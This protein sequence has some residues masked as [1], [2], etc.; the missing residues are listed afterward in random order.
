MVRALLI[1]ALVITSGGAPSRA[2][3]CRVRPQNPFALFDQAAS[4]AVVRV[5]NVDVPHPMGKHGYRKGPVKATLD[6]QHML[7]GPAVG[8]LVARSSLLTCDVNFQSGEIGIVMLGRNGRPLGLSEG[9]RRDVARWQ[10]PLEGWANA[11]SPADRAAVLVDALIG[12]DA[13]VASAAAHYLLYSNPK[14]LTQIN[15]AQRARL[16]SFTKADP[17]RAQPARQ[18]LARLVRH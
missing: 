13:I 14:L 3:A 4:V 12:T 6:V 7:K 10:V 17:Q 15:T 2:E 5:L 1:A 16:E 8:Q 18:V 11:S 9:F